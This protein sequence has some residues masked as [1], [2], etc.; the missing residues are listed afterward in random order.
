MVDVYSA[1]LFIPKHVFISD[2]SM[3]VAVSSFQ[4][5]HASVLSAPPNL[6]P[7]TYYPVSEASNNGSGAVSHTTA[8]LLH[9]IFDGAPL[10][11]LEYL[12]L[13]VVDMNGELFEFN[14]IDWSASIAIAYTSQSP[15]ST[16]VSSRTK[17]INSI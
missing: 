8:P 3:C 12:D 17:E 6:P 10:P 1:S 13:S 7:S 16:G 15:V 5:S 9:Q 11:V 4:R 2:L 14:N